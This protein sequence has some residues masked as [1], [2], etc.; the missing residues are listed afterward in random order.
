MLY[1]FPPN[2]FAAIERGYED[3]A[4]RWGPIVDVFEAEGVSSRWSA[5]PRSP[6]TS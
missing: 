4:E 2:D 6:T 5:R 1:S 3:F